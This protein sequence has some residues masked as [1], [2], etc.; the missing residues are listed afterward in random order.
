MEM[1]TGNG[2]MSA[3]EMI[4]AN[5]AAE[6]QEIGALRGMLQQYA[7]QIEE[8]K[9]LYQENNLL[10]NELKRM[11]I[12]TTRSVQEVMGTVSTRLA[13]TPAHAQGAVDAQTGE[14]INQLHTDVESM[15]QQT[16]E[17]LQQLQARTADLIQQSDDFS[18]KENVRVYRNIQAATDQ[19]LQKQ[20]QE[21]K[22]NISSLTKEKKKKPSFL[23]ILTFLM[24]FLSLAWQVCDRFGVIDYAL[25]MIIR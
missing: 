5:G 4:R 19:L 22:D 10:I 12:E 25:S 1:T 23:L 16:V 8:L 15:H 9:A 3:D 17:E 6:A 7:K 2:N 11:N 18:H 14:G 20:T 24:S 21:L 13:E